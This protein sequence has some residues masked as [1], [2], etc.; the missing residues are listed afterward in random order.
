V[1]EAQTSGM[2]ESSLRLRLKDNEHMGQTG[3]YFLAHQHEAKADN[4]ERQRVADSP[5]HAKL[6]RTVAALLTA[7]ERRHRGDVIRFERVAFRG[8]TRNRN[9]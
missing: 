5:A 1:N 2:F 7:D 8:A 4:E 9:S 3:R 6:G